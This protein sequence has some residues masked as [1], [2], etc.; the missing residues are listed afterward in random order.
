MRAFAATADAKNMCACAGVWCTFSA[1]IRTH[2]A[3][4][5]A[6]DLCK[7]WTHK[8]V[9]FHEIWDLC[10]GKMEKEEFALHNRVYHMGR[11]SG[12]LVDL[13]ADQGLC[14]ETK[15]RVAQIRNMFRGT[16]EGAANETALPAD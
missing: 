2:K 3:E 15:K 8:M 11:E 4:R 10:D 7:A 14:R 13:E 5:I 1:N 6:T 12:E 16:V 9:W